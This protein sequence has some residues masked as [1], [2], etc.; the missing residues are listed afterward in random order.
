MGFGAMF[1][2]QLDN[3]KSKHCRHPIAIMFGQ[4]LVAYPR[5]CNKN[6]CDN[7]REKYLVACSWKSKVWKNETLKTQKAVSLG[8]NP[9]SFCTY[10][11][12]S[13]FIKWWIQKEKNPNSVYLKTT[14]STFTLGLLYTMKIN[15]MITKRNNRPYVVE[16]LEKWNPKKLK[17][18]IVWNEYS[19]KKMLFHTFSFF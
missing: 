17:S 13:N 1:T 5:I 11:Q 16:S 15:V 2:F 7:H 10:T 14:T 3:T 8:M 9:L 19:M 12:T 18:C 6:K 4:Y